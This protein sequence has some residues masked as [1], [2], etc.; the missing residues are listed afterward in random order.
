MSAVLIIRLFQ[1]QERWCWCNYQFDIMS[2]TMRPVD[3]RPHTDTQ[4]I[5]LWLVEKKSACMLAQVKMLMMSVWE[6]P[7]LNV[8]RNYPHWYLN[9]SWDYSHWC[10][11]VNWDYYHWGLNVSWDYPHWGLDVSWVCPRWDLNASWDYPHGGL[12]ASLDIPHW[13]LN[14]SLDHP[15][16]VFS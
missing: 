9:V 16:W 10:L 7:H 12:N 3:A 4:F 8:S 15:Y 6:V 14:V 11:N 13:G 2:R 1:D 5:V